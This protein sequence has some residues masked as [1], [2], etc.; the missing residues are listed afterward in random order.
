MA[1]LTPSQKA[2]DIRDY[3]D[4]PDDMEPG[5]PKFKQ[6]LDPETGVVYCPGMKVHE[7]GRIERIPRLD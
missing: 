1:E 7:D 2:F 4:N 5:E 3:L 6:I